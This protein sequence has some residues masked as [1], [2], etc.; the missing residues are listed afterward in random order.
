MITDFTCI[1]ARAEKKEDAHESSE[2]NNPSDD[3]MEKYGQLG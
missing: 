2:I 1:Q 3:C